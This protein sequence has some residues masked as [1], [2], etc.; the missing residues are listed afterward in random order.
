MC[1][2]GHMSTQLVLS[3]EPNGATRETVTKRVNS[4]RHTLAFSCSRA[5]CGF[6]KASKSVALSFSKLPSI[7]AQILQTKQWQKMNLRQWGEHQVLTWVHKSCWPETQA[8]LVF[9]CLLSAEIVDTVIYTAT[10][11]TRGRAAIILR[12]QGGLSC[13]CSHNLTDW[14]TVM[15][16]CFI[17]KAQ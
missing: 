9:S 13:D 15:F 8:A 17:D 10:V 3:F 6:A 12:L 5:T 11:C 1:T 16:H 14:P 4:T 7:R 2:G